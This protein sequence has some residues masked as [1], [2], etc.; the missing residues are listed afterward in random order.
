MS[1]VITRSVLARSIATQSVVVVEALGN[2]FYRNGHL[3]GA[4]N[5]PL[6]SPD[7]LLQL[8][9]NTAAMPVVVYGSRNGGEA[10]ELAHRIE[11]L[12]RCQVLVYASGKEDWVEAGLL[13][14]R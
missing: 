8:T 14:E 12:C 6:S 7:A 2:D 13:V 3:P 11:R 4:I 5:L 10:S 9:L 1:T